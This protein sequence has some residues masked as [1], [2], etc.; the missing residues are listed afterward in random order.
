MAIHTRKVIP[1]N[2]PSQ[3]DS[4]PE[5]INN[6]QPEMQAIQEKKLTTDQNSQQQDKTVVNE[7]LKNLLDQQLKTIPYHDNNMM[8]NNNSNMSGKNLIFILLFILLGIIALVGLVL[9]IKSKSS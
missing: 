3:P 2:Q 7:S 5:K 8:L 4:I 6:K 1:N 9:Y